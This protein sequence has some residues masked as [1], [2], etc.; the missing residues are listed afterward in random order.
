MNQRFF[1]S[2]GVFSMMPL[3]RF[4]NI[5]KHKRFSIRLT[6]KQWL[7][8]WGDFA[9]RG[10]VIW[11]RLETVLVVTTW[12]ALLAC[13]GWGPGM[14]LNTLHCTGQSLTTKNRPAQNVRSAEAEKHWSKS[15]LEREGKKTSFVSVSVS[16]CSEEEKRI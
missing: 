12:G 5:V 15:T 14:L 8:I 9:P 6:W 3:L 7:S 1:Y 10:V 13:S 16:S 2:V 11:Q 4:Y